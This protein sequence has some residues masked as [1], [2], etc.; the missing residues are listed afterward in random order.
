[1]KIFFL[2]VLLVGSVVLQY[3]YVD[4]C[5]N[6]NGVFFSINYDLMIILMVE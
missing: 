3:V 5:K 2:F 4:V 1:M 6:V